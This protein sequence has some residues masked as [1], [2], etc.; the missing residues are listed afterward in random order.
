[1]MI[2]WRASGDI[3]A[4]DAVYRE[5]LQNLAKADP[6]T[7]SADQRTIQGYLNELYEEG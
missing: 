7:L 1:L 4:S 2:M 6:G 5:D 3:V